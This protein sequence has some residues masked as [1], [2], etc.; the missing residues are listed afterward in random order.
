MKTTLLGV[1]LALVAALA[2]TGSATAA[3]DTNALP[4][5]SDAERV[6]AMTP[7][8]DVGAAEDTPAAA[9][10]FATFEKQTIQRWFELDPAAAVYQG[11]H[12]FDGQLPDW[13][14]AGLATRSAFLH[15]VIDQARAFTGLS[16]QDA[17][18]RDALVWLARKN[19]FWLVTADW[20]HKN[21]HWYIDNGLDP[22]TYLAR[23]Y[24]DK[25]TRMKALIAFF[26]AVPKAAAEIR[27]NLKTPMP[28]SYVDSGIASF[29]GFADFYRNDAPKAFADVADPALQAQ[30]R[31][32]S[33]AAAS[34]MDALTTWIKAQKPQATQGFAMGPELFSGMLRET[35]AVDIPLDQ[36]RQVG[37]A[38]LARNQAALKDACAQYAPGKTIA[39]C[40]GKANADKPD[41]GPVAA[42][43]RMIPE[44][45]AFVREKDLVTIPGTEQALVEESPPYNRQNSAYIDPPGPLDKGLASVYY[46][47]PPDPAWS[48]EKQL[49]YIPGRGDTLFTTIHEVMPGHFVQ[50]LHS[51]RSP[52]LVGSLFVGY[53]YAE[54][55]AHYSEELMW[56]AGYGNGDPGAHVGQLT[57]ALL[58]DCRFLSAIGLHAGGMTQAQSDAMFQN[59]CY[60]DPGNAEQQAARGTYDPAY[61][62]YTLGKLM[63]RKLR[64]DWTASR[65]GRTA[66]K[67]FHDQF[68]SYGGL[69]IPLVRQAM[70]HEPEPKAVF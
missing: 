6:S 13:S 7:P 12:R 63:I 17:L 42:A 41:G 54:G 50:F 8:P 51:N 61:L 57:N 20:P 62:N 16:P 69:P 3:P 55:W 30:L 38:D 31:G 52:S 10:A 5:A 34:A 21:P 49:A 46:I 65:G 67:P 25:P 39:E 60:Q 26:R 56:E 2:L 23:E 24:A 18:E 70:M 44:L 22:N 35:E 11:D 15:S 33:A 19:V 9:S 68:L 53:A 4:R 45:T 27:A 28:L 29:G 36:L 59:E 64:T 43:R 40:T 58:R 1:P 14:D 47:S 66:W 48:K 32:S 37:R